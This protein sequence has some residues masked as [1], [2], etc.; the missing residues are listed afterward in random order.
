MTT[1]QAK[2]PA[3]ILTALALGLAVAWAT[4]NAVPYVA[5]AA[6]SLIPAGSVTLAPLPEIASR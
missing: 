2:A 3:S 5:G 6:M 1:Q 4:F